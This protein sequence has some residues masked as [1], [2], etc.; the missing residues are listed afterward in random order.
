MGVVDDFMANVRK[1]IDYLTG[2]NPAAAAQGTTPYAQKLEEA[3]G[4]EKNEG[5]TPQ[6]P[7]VGMER[8]Y[9]E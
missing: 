8:T 5:K 9:N 6:T 1:G 3:A 7:P 2:S 4:I